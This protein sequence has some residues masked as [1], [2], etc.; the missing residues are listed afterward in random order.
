MKKI[1]LLLLSIVSISSC[2]QPEVINW[3]NWNTWN[4]KAELADK[5]GLVFINSPTCDDCQAMKDTTFQNPQIVAFMNQHFH[6]IKLDVNE[7]EDITTKGRTW[8][9]IKN[10]GSKDSYHELAKALS[11]ATDYISTPTTV[12]L[13]ENFDLI[14]PIPGRLTAQEMDLLLHFVEEEAYTQQSID[15]YEKT[16][17]SSVKDIRH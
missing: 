5:K 3:L 2:S 13:N 1:I 7:E 17:T 8:R 15:D 10:F 9:N 4:E 11:Q 6:A 14:I 12:F 16:F